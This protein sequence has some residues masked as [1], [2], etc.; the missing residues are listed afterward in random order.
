MTDIIENVL[1][2]LRRNEEG[3]I[4]T[5][6]H[7]KPKL[8]S[9]FILRLWPDTAVEAGGQHSSVAAQSD[10][11]TTVLS[12][13]YVNVDASAVESGALTIKA[14]IPQVRSEKQVTLSD[15]KEV[16]NEVPVWLPARK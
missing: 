6:Q 3:H 9:P 1:S 7:H 13:D 11:I 15:D 10:S 12:V 5:L 2:R 4:Q 16:Q 8:R 14:I